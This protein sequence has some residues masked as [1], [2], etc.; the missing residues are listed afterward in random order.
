M[1][2]MDKWFNE[3]H[4]QLYTPIKQWCFAEY[5]SIVLQDREKRDQ[6]LPGSL[7]PYTRK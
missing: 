5:P 2:T 1:G 6:N 7:P 4:N 3:S